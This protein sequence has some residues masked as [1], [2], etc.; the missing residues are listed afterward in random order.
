MYVYIYMRIY[1]YVHIMYIYNHFQFPHLYC[2]P[3]TYGFGDILRNPHN[4]IVRIYIYNIY[5][6]ISYY[7]IVEYL[8]WLN[9]IEYYISI[10]I[11]IHRNIIIFWSIFSHA[12]PWPP[13]S[14]AARR[15]RSV[16]RDLKGPA[17]IAR[18]N[19]PGENTPVTLGLIDIDIELLGKW[20]ENDR[21]LWN[22]W[23]SIGE[24]DL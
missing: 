17:C 2:L 7:V 19:A 3:E 22:P 12:K 21:K 23:A 6:Y 10:Y 16:R 1:I 20:W 14:R 5:I 24:N 4:Y 15:G 18:W 9:M 11:Y 8:P 13:G